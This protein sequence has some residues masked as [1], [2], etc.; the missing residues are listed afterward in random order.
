MHISDSVR[1]TSPCT[2]LEVIIVVLPE[3]IRRLLWPLSEC[4]EDRSSKMWIWFPALSSNCFKIPG[5]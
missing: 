1:L 4:L 2:A 3:A 5:T